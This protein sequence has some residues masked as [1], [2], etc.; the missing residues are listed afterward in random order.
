M[1]PNTDT[2]PIESFA[3]LL[4]RALG[5]AVRADATTFLDMLAQ[6]CVMVF[7]YSPAG[8]VRRLEGRAAVARH[9][10]QLSGLIEFDEMI[11]LV[12]HPSQAAG[13]FVLEFGCTGRGVQTNE[14]YDQR[15][16]SVITIRDR[17]IVHYRD[18]WNPLIVLSAVGGV[19][20]LN[21]ALEGSR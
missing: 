6:D 1:D 21:A 8:S 17:Q 12:V 7:P 5:D 14:P 3:E 4:R 11:D 20:A 2:D 18:Y 16:I 10:G 15:Y 13:V 9:L 19:E